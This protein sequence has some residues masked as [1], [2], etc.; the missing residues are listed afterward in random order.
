M[1]LSK[2]K[3]LGSLQSRTIFG[4]TSPAMN[5]MVLPVDAAISSQGRIAVI[6]AGNSHLFSNN[7]T[8]ITA[9]QVDSNRDCTQPGGDDPLP[10]IPMGQPTAVGWLDENT[11]VV[12][13]REPANLQILRQ[14]QTPVFIDLSNVRREDTGHAVFHSNSGVGV[15]CASCHPEGGDDGRT[16][17]FDPIGPRRTQSL[18]GGILQTAPFHWDGELSNMQ[19]LFDEVMVKRMSGPALPDGQVSALAGWVDKVPA[20][21]VS[22]AADAAAVERGRAIFNDP[23]GAACA[24][25]HSGARFTNNAAYDVG[26]GGRFQVPTLVDIAFRAPY[27]HDGCAAT[28]RDRFGACGGGD[29]HGRTSQ[30]SQAQIGDLVSYLETL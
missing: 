18:R 24:S 3:K 28:L 22:P 23:N 26:T 12:Q 4:S 8:I 14:F 10:G 30:L 11:L 1:D 5:D 17:V 25:C 15:A 9:A 19:V 29:R 2:F 21:S 27:I 16:W 7:L 13:S 6:A 20:V